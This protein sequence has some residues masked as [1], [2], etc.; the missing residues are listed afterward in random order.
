MFAL[1]RRPVGSRVV[2][3]LVLATCLLPACNSSSPSPRT[4]DPAAH[5]KVLQH[6]RSAFEFGFDREDDR[7][8]LEKFLAGSAS[9]ADRAQLV[10]AWNAVAELGTAQPEFLEKQ[11]FAKALAEPDW[12]TDPRRRAG[13]VRRRHARRAGGLPR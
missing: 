2:A 10:D 13:R 5:E 7:A 11:I 4:F 1:I 8:P 3:A 6:A 12:P 9:A